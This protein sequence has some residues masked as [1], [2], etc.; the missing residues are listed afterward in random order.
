MHV[1]SSES[2]ASNFKIFLWFLVIFAI[3]HVGIKWVSANLDYWRLDDDI[4]SK[5]TMGQVLKDDEIKADL[6][7]KAKEYDLPLTADNFIIV[8]NESQQRL[9]IRTAWDVEVRYF[10]GICGENCVQTYHF[11]PKGE[12]SYAS[13]R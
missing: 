11:E 2:G 7:K 1:A 9:S 4:K 6:A 13:G 3:L 5:S 12:G 8:R 10:W